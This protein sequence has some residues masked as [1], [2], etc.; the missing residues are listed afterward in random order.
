MDKTSFVWLGAFAILAGCSTAPSDMTFLEDALV[1]YKRALVSAQERIVLEEFAK[2]HTWGKAAVTLYHIEAVTLEPQT[3]LTRGSKT[4]LGG[5]VGGI[6]MP[7]G[8]LTA[9]REVA[10]SNDQGGKISIHLKAYEYGKTKIAQD[11]FNNTTPNEIYTI[12][13]YDEK[14]EMSYD[15]AVGGTA[16]ESFKNS[17]CGNPHTFLHCVPI[18]GYIVNDRQAYAKIPNANIVKFRTMLN[19]LHQKLDG[20]LLVN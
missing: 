2:Y 17:P 9:S 7:I 15:A 19:G 4:S 12:T 10:V 16:N 3:K 20:E 11:Y 1:S 6:P 8:R 5:E 18:T 13:W 14:S